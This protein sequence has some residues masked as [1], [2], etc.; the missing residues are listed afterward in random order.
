MMRRFDAVTTQQ[1]KKTHH[2]ALEGEHSQG[3]SPEAVPSLNSF[4]SGSSGYKSLSSASSEAFQEVLAHAEVIPSEQLPVVSEWVE[5]RFWFRLHKYFFVFAVVV[6][7][8]MMCNSIEFHW[9]VQN[10][11]VPYCSQQL[12]PF[13]S[14]IY[15]FLPLYSTILPSSLTSSCHLFLGLPLGLVVSKFIYSTLLGIQFSSIL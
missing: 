10:V 14:V 11:M 8:C 7:G 9:H 6:L 2:R 13:L 5:V 4:G 15:F 1:V 12:L 3:H